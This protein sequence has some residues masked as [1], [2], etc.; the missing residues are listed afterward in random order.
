[1]KIVDGRL[2]AYAGVEGLV[3]VPQENARDACPGGDGD[4]TVELEGH[5]GSDT[6]KE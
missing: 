3:A 5:S 4:N 6:C 1:M 2:D